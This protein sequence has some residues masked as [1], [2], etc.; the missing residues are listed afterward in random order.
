MKHHVSYTSLARRISVLVITVSLA[1]LLLLSFLTAYQFHT[2]YKAKVLA[3]I[4]EIVAK[5]R[6][7]INNFLQ[8]KLSEIQ[9]LAESLDMAQLSDPNYLE[10][11]LVRLQKHYGASYVDLGFVNSDGDQIAYA[12]PFKLEHAH[13]SKSDWFNATMENGYSLS[14]VFLGLRGLPH[15]IVA[16]KY[17]HADHNYILRATIDFEAFNRLV[18]DIRLGSTGLAFIINRKGAFQ[19]TPRFDLSGSVP[20]Y[21]DLIDEQMAEQRQIRKETGKAPAVHAFIRPKPIG[22]GEAIFVTA[23]LKNGDW[24]LVY[25]QDTEDAFRDLFKTRDLAMS[26]LLIGSFLIMA[27]ELLIAKRIVDHIS[28]SEREK[29][30][31]NEQM[32]EAGKMASLGEL[33]AGIAHEIN[34]PV[35]VMVEEA[36]WVED[37][38]GDEPHPTKKTNEE[39]MRSLKQ[40]RIQGARCKEITKKLLS[41]ARKTDSRR[42]EIQLNDLVMEV[43]SL[44]DQ[45]ARYGNITVHVDLEHSL[46]LVSVA[47]SEMQQVLLN[48]INNAVHAMEEKGGEIYVSTRRKNNMVALVLQDTGCGIPESILPRIFE[49]FFTTKPV[50]KGTGL[51]L[52]ICYGIVKNMGGDILVESVVGTGTTFT[53]LLP[54][55]TSAPSAQTGTGTLQAGAIKR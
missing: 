18:E 10:K 4:E 52:S 14:D 3:H 8:D 13:Y 41:F 46:P 35:A 48:L 40:I 20:F 50:G 16:V 27:T 29:E 37:M 2:A 12:G 38:V 17:P 51:G 21:L 39:I 43:V 42:K 9:V 28:R 31:M 5:H 44:T 45:K 33:A 23:S 15:F 49:P 36:G 47:E 19:T 6:Q 26:I 34:N 24:T 55:V 30:L 32:I 53:I 1:P 25:Q 54:L 11:L 7:H 22:G